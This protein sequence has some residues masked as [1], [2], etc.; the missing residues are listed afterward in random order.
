MFAT[1]SRIAITACAAVCVVSIAL[2]ASANPNLGPLPDVGVQFHGTWA[3]YSDEE[4]VDFLTA[5]RDAG[6]TTV[7]IDVS[8]A[9]LEPAYR[10]LFDPWGVDIVDRLV[11]MCNDYGITPLMTLWMTPGWANNNAGPYTL[12]TDVEDY[13]RVAQWAAARYTDKVAGWEVWNEQNSPAFLVGADPVAYINLLKVAYRALHAGYADTTVVFGG[14]EYNDDEWLARAYAAGAQGHFDVMSTHPYMGVAN[15]PPD[16]PDD[17]TKWTLTHAA[18]IRELMIANGDADKSIWFTEF[19]WSS[20]DNLAGTPNWLLGVPEAVQA[21]YFTDTI[22]LI[23]S[24]MSWVG[25]VYW[26]T[27]YDSTDDHSIDVEQKIHYDIL[28]RDQ[29]PKPVM[30]AI[31]SAGF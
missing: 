13:A 27:G 6:V 28:R 9:M 24:T 20:H 2:P 26:Y 23:R 12:P 7:R 11:E 3:R 19:G 18:A 4:R 1:I 21:Q 29:S 17:G 16:T 14:L 15:L 22:S 10:G 25:K 31:S 30:S 5:L 8:W